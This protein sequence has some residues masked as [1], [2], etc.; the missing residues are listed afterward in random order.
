MSTTATELVEQPTASSFREP[1]LRVLGRLSGL[2]AGYG[3][4][5]QA[6][7]DAVCQE[8]G[9]TENQFGTDGP[10]GAPRLRVVIQQAYGK[11][12]CYHELARSAERGVWVLTEAG[13][14]I[15]TTLL[16]AVTIEDAPVP[17]PAFGGGEGL[18]WTP[19]P[20]FNTY[21]PDAYIRSL[22]IAATPCF[23]EFSD[24]SEVCGRCPLSG[25]CK[26]T[27]LVRLAD[28]ARELR[29]RDA[30]LRLKAEREAAALARGEIIASEKE[31]EVA[32]EEEDIDSIIAAIEAN[33][34]GEAKEIDVPVASKCAKCADK[35]DRGTKGMF[36][37]G[38][39]IY[40]KHCYEM[41]HGKK[42]A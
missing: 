11:N 17:Q 10:T 22:A 26:A 18:A 2:Q 39:G 36:I 19:G 41:V 25:A 20:Q 16:A 21:N 14:E 4:P 23:G 6:A 33:S 35:I 29:E 3:V 7:I 42:N 24:R 28:C 15:A 1:L 8:T 9:F 12:L 40:H 37:A 34:V 31:P 5:M 27:L 30:A 13:V 38:T 32:E